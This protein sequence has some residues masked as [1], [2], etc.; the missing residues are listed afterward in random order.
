MAHPKGEY[1]A[2]SEVE[3]EPYLS[4]VPEAGAVETLETEATVIR[5]VTDA[6]R[7][8]LPPGA[9][10]RIIEPAEGASPQEWAKYAV[11][12][13]LAKSTTATGS[14]QMRNNNV[15]RDT[16]FTHGFTKRFS[17]PTS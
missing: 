12:V 14:G 6:M 2:F 8:M 10:G 5:I 11:Q 1:A 9:V 4:V 13:R 16:P 17:D 7:R 3:T 15:R